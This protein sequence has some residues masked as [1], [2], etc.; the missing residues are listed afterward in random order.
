M[1]SERYLS[2]VGGTAAI[3]GVVVMIASTM[4]HPLDAQPGDAPAA[5]VE[6]ADDDTWV[7][8]HLGQL[9]GIVLV[10]AGFAALSWRLREGRAGV[11]ALLAGLTMVVSVSLAGA[12]QAVDGVALK[13]MVDRW[14]AA[15][16]NPAV[17]F[18][19][20]FGVRQIEVG[21]ASLMGV[22]FG[23]TVLLYGVAILMSRVIPKWL[24]MFGILAGLATL[25]SSTIQGHVGFS[26]VAMTTSTP[27]T[28]AVLVWSICIGVFLLRKPGEQEHAA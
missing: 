11:W 3:V 19:A 5:F 20:A 1:L 16:D 2:R 24:G 14:T 9:L 22:F 6:Y 27:S 28:L 26:N 4:M 21:F 7:V 25:T 12:L 13:F 15:G 23:L 17:I 10:G 8:T 18:E